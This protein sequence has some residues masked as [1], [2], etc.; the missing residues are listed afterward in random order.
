MMNAAPK[1]P[2][3]EQFLSESHEILE[4]VGQKLMQ[5]ENAPNDQDVINE[6]FRMVHTLKGNSGLFTFPE[7]TRVLHAGEDVLG[8]VRNSEM[9]FSRELADRLLDAMDFVGLLLH[10]IESTECIDASRAT[11]SVRLA[12]SLRALMAEF[13]ASAATDP[14]ESTPGTTKSI[15]VTLTGVPPLSE[16]PEAL[17]I[18][19]F[20][21]CGDG[22]KFHWIAYQPDPE[23]FFQGDD[24]F[25]RARQTPGLL[26]GSVLPSEPLRP[27]AELDTYR[28]SLKFHLLTAAFHEE[29][30]EYFR[31]VPDQVKIVAVDPLWLTISGYKSEN[32][33]QTTSDSVNEAPSS[34]QERSPESIEESTALDRI[35]A[36]QRQILA[37][38]DQPVWQAGR[39]KAVA[40]VL[41]NLS[42]IA[43]DAA[44]ESQ[45]EAALSASLASGGSA[46]LLDWLNAHESQFIAPPVPV[47]AANVSQMNA[48][49]QTVDLDSDADANA[50][51]P[52]DDGIKYGRRADDGIKF[53]RRSEDNQTGPRSLKVDQAKIDRL[54]NLIGELVVEKNALPY[55]ARRAEAQYGVRELSREIKGKYS[56]INRI[57]DEMQDAIMQVRMM[58]VSFVFQR[59]PRLVRDTSRKLGK[60]VQLVLEGEQTEAD[61]NIIE[62][63]ADPLIHIVRNSLDH[64]F[65]VP[66]VRR[67]NGKPETGTLTIRAAQQADRVVIEIVDDGKGID[68]AVIKR[69]AYE[70]GLIDEAALERMDDREAVNLIFAAGLSTAT[71]VSDLSG[72]GVGMD[73]VRTAVEKL[74]GSVIVE[75]VLG[76]GTS[77]CI[78]LPLSMAVTQVMIIESDGQLFGV[79][80]DHVIETVRL[81]RSSIHRIKQSMTAILRGRVV[82]LKALNSLLGIPAQP[83]ANTDDELSILLV[84]AGGGVMGLLVDGFRETLGVIQKPM[85]GFLSN[86]ST[87]SGSALMGDGSVLMILNIREIV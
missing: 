58:E 20:R 39:L 59:F 8:K 4:G 24:P 25:H 18:E 51:K 83:T 60:E 72:R 13:S 69:K 43:N 12:E 32:K 30:V 3:L 65:E 50:A 41:V 26:W 73:V 52:V 10:E 71:V 49:A 7:M 55:L 38:N 2:L 44:V 9:T 70:K 29:L 75:S 28:C 37:F 53:G 23:C 78:S 86:L 74:N 35:L 81:P 31:Y 14:A 42:R 57:A 66:E 67:A 16:I 87:W 19:A 36:A 1:N 46:P 15:A 63:L 85:A 5:L 77:I 40:A 84:Q 80:M 82:P 48:D 47:S 33:S 21:R 11:D 61:K 79:P 68:P 22:E 76:K 64:G 54:M 27:L 34:L 6:L 56:V 17:R 45:I 62:A